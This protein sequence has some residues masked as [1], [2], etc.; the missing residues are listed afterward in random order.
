M[1]AI[2]I[3]YVARAHGVRGEL[4]V[5][6][7]N[8]ESDTLERVD[9]VFVG[10]REYQITRARPTKG[11]VLLSLVGLDDRDQAEAAR[12]Q[13]VLVAREL[14]PVDEGELLLADLIGCQAV[15]ASGEVYGTVVAVEPGPQDRLVIATGA[16]ERLLPLVSELVLEID[17]EDARV[18]VDPPI[19]LPEYRASEDRGGRA[20]GRETG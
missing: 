18:V 17:L 8:P 3:G 13:K 1:R 14:I 11:A 10:E 19:G 20:G 16:V 12:G 15:L 2:E 9:R 7:H 4:R 5:V 6:L